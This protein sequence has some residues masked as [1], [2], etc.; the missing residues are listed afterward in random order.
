MIIL[1][2]CTTPDAPFLVL[3]FSPKLE[4]IN[5]IGTLSSEHEPNKN[6]FHN[7]KL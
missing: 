1:F 6:L 2:A 7:T 3:I 5:R 4:S